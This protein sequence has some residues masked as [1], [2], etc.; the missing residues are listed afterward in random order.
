MKKTGTSKN[1]NLATY[2][3]LGLAL[4]A[5][6]FLGVVSPNRGQ[7]TLGA[8]AAKVDKDDITRSEFSTRYKNQLSYYQQTHGQDFKPGS[9]GLANKVLNEI[10]K[11]RTWYQTAKEN[12]SLASIEEVSSQIAD[13]P[14]F[15][16]KDGKFS[17]K[18]MNQILRANGLTEAS[19]AK[20]FRMSLSSEKL[21][22]QIVNQI[23]IPTQMIN[24]MY[25]LQETKVELSYVKIEKAK[26]KIKVSKESVDKYLANEKSSAEIKSHY[27]RFKASY[28]AE[29]EVRARQLL[30]SFKGAERSNESSAKRTKA[31]A[32]KKAKRLLADIKRSPKKFVSI[33]KKETD[34]LFSKA[35]DGDLDFI[36]FNEMPKEFSTVVFKMKKGA[37]S[38]PIE[39]KFG[40]HIV[41]VEDIQEAKNI[42]LEKAAPSI[43]EKLL[44]TKERNK[45]ATDLS[46]KLLAGFKAG[47]NEKDLM[48]AHG[49]KWE[50]TPKMTLVSRSLPGFPKEFSEAALSLNKKN[51]VLPKVIKKQDVNYLV[52]LSSKEKADLSKLTDE[53]KLDIERV[54]KQ[55]EAR[56]LLSSYEKTIWETYQDPKKHT[57]YINPQY[58]ALD[59]GA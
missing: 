35:T 48:K 13:I 31:E 46:N 3:I 39:T 17:E 54:L 34:D 27:S 58:K 52:K 57:I 6:A 9:I 24:L 49:L 50:T 47:K 8:I 10:I 56:E 23:F 33:I 59:S 43:A 55:K 14:S 32:L 22:G 4:V 2:I 7:E 28:Q 42:S 40:Y 29:K 18:L 53:K 38:E 37:I 41:R 25:L 21:K 15:Y 19:L 16:D 11:E 20:R 12:G 44:E 26:L 51:N 1:K 45:Q 36:E 30:V 5:I